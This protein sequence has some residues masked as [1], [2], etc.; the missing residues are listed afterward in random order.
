M[1]HKQGIFSSRLWRERILPGA[2]FFAVLFEFTFYLVRFIL[3][4]ALF[5]PFMVVRPAAFV[6]EGLLLLGVI[7]SK[8]KTRSFLLF[9][10]CWLLLTRCFLGDLGPTSLFSIQW[11]IVLVCFFLVRFC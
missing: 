10:V 8:E 3:P 5:R 9:N 6:C 7:L 1:E 2:A 4:E 11:A